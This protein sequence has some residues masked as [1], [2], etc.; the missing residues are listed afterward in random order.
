M[1]DALKSSDP[2]EPYQNSIYQLQAGCNPGLSSNYYSFSSCS[3]C[4]M[5]TYADTP[6]SCG[7]N[8]CQGVS[9]TDAEGSIDA[10]NCSACQ[11]GYCNNHG[12]CS[13]DPD[14]KLPSCHCDI[15]Y[16]SSDHCSM[17]WLFI[18]P[19]TAIVLFIIIF[20]SF[21]KFLQWKRKT[22]LRKAQI[23]QSNREI[24]ALRAAWV[25]P[26]TE[27]QYGPKVDQGT[28]VKGTCVYVCVVC[29]C[30]CDCLCVCV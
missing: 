17:A 5:G 11:P 26:H 13:L 18:V 19:I 22:R 2:F 1:L 23:A 21:R 20:F 15:G 12:S 14:T 8:T 7:C 28:T 9:W 3:Q 16:I 27:I 4:A 30:V 6:G 25:I 29:I 24:E 10:K